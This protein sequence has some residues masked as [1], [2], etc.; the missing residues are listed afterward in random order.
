MLEEKPR[1]TK[2]TRSKVSFERDSTNVNPR[3]AFDTFRSRHCTD[4]E[5]LSAFLDT[6]QLFKPRNLFS[7]ETNL[8]IRLEHVLVLRCGFKTH[9][10]G[11]VTSL[12]I[13]FIYS[14]SAILVMQR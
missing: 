14:I 8:L 5:E 1:V 10:V 4:S 3:A 12:K 7:V 11:E 6:L 9:L 13:K 2:G